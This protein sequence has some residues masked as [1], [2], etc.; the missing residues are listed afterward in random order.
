M[1]RACAL[2]ALTAITFGTT[3]CRPAAPVAPGL[4]AQKPKAESELAFVTIS[5][6]AYSALAIQTKTVA[7]EPVQERVTLTG[8]VMA[9][10]GHEVTVTAPA[11]GYVRLGKGQTQAPTAGAAIKADQELLVLEPVLAPVEQI[12]LAALKRGVES[13]LAKA[14]AS[15]QTATSEY[16]RLRDLQAQ[17]LRSLQDV[18]QAQ[19]IFEHAKEDL[20]AAQD[21]LKLFVATNIP[22]RAPRAGAVLAL[23]ASPGQYV[24]AAAPVATVIDLQPVWLRV[25]VPEYDLPQVDPLQVV[26]VTWRQG[27]G[28]TSQTFL[29]AQ[30]TGRVS[31]VDP[32]KHTADF[33]YGLELAKDS[34]PFVK[35]QMLTVHV[36][37]GKKQPATVL[38]YAA[39]VFDA[40]GSAWIYLERTTDQ[41]KQHR[42]ER[43]RIDLGAPADQGLIVRSG[44][45]QGERVVIRGAAELFSSEFH[46]TPVRI[47]GED[48]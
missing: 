28:A 24:A 3:G 19:K 36:P 41:D 12:Q 4:A 43:R 13:E 17:N 34:P 26:T 38:P 11:A 46:K 37:I 44:L 7:L 48:D 25:P 23:H 47:A 6:K 45:T 31:Q 22:L 42:F 5:K 15:V 32:L 8:W 33:W 14:K 20:A 2:L 27:E 30:P 1:L 29:R 18:E 21:K 10:P 35:D 40:Q 9:K 39:V 16:Q